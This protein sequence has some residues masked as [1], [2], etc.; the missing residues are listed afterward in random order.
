[1]MSLLRLLHS[2]AARRGDG[3]RAE[4]LRPM[5]PSPTLLSLDRQISAN[6]NRIALQPGAN[7]GERASGAGR[8][9]ED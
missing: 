1:M 6:E 8:D 5:A 7:S 2:I 3:L 4:F 9:N